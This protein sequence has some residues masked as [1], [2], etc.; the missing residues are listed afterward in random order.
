[1]PSNEGFNSQ[2]LRGNT[3]NQHEQQDQNSNQLEMGEKFVFPHFLY[4]ELIT[5]KTIYA[6]Y[7]EGMGPWN[8][9]AVALADQTDFGDLCRGKFTHQQFC[10]FRCCF[11]TGKNLV[12]LVKLRHLV[13]LFYMFC[14]IIKN[15]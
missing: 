15:E 1:M 14:S 4:I 3:E 2:M 9:R 8:Y 13:R 5:P 12:L 10:T 11:I 6:K 7:N